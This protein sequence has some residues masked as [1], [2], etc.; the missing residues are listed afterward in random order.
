MLRPSDDSVFSPLECS[1]ESSGYVNSD[2]DPTHR[3]HTYM[4]LQDDTRDRSNSRAYESLIYHS[5]E[6][7]GSVNDTYDRLTPIASR[8]LSIK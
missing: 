1:Y 4:R 2:E 6:N 7:E 8:T 5:F 3:K